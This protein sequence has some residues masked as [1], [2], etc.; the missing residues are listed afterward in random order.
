M[1]AGAGR[2]HHRH[3][4]G[5]PGPRGDGQAVGL[6]ADARPRSRRWLD[7]GGGRRRRVPV[8]LKM[9][10]GWDDAS[11]NAPE[12]ARRAEAAGVQLITVHGRTRCQFFKGAADWAFV[13]RV[14][15]AVSHSRRRQR[16]HRRSAASAR[17][18]LDA[19]GAD[20][21]MVGRGAYGAPWMPARIAAFLATGRDP[22]TPPLAEQGAIA[23]RARRGHA[24]ALRR[25]PRPA[26][27]PQAHRLVPGQQRPRRRGRQGVAAAAVHGGGCRARCWRA[28]QP[29]TPKPQEAGG[30]S[31]ESRTRAHGPSSH[32]PPHRA[33]PAARGAAAPDPR[34]RRRRPRR[35]MP[36]RPPSLLLAQPRHAEAP[37]AA[38]IIAFGC[39][40]LRA[41]RRRCARTGATVN[42]YGVDVALPR[43]RRH[44]KLVDVFAGADAGPAGPDRAHAAA[45][46]DGA[47]DRAPAHASRRRALGLGHGRDAGARDQEPAVGHPRRRA[48]AGAGRS[49]TRTAR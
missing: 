17:A 35:S 12:L 43:S 31:T 18:A 20:A 41:G 33:R 48:A 45:A 23:D 7:R 9:R 19:S 13:R 16:R 4:H 5:L 49:R 21:V 11:R 2:R 25:A 6:G 24:R 40:L 44:R 27:R 42:E 14:K 39:P 30:M 34:A 8:T 32:A 37:D 38:D 29:S 36:T 1:A 10:L 26:Q 22:G 46:L 15:E 28:S 47:D 3:Q